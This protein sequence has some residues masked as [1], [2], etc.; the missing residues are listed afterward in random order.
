[1]R[2]D[3]LT[4]TRFVA[5]TSIVVYHFGTDIFPFK[6]ELVSFLFRQSNIGVSYFFTLSGFVMIIAYGGKSIINMVDYYKN[7]I[8]R[9]YPVYLL[10]I[11]ML[12]AYL[13]LFRSAINY[14]GLVLN[15][16]AVQ[17]WI[18]GKA[19]SFNAP[20]WSLSVEFLFYLVFP[21]L[22][23]Y[24]YTKTSLKTIGLFI[25]IFWSIS[26]LLFHLSFKLDLYHP[27][28]S[29]SHDL[30]LYF[31]LFHLNEF[32]IGNL[33]GLIFLDISKKNK[34]NLDWPVLIT[35]FLITLALKYKGWLNINYHNGAL[36]ILFMVFIL[37]LSINNGILTSIASHRF[38]VFLGEISYGI[39]IFQIPV[40]MWM[41]KVLK[42][43]QI[44]NLE[45]KFFISLIILILI[46][47]M[48]YIFIETPLRDK[49]KTLNLRHI[50]VFSRVRN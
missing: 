11:L 32:L 24:L 41:G 34:R 3:Q 36:S 21:F 9:I 44:Y 26:Q 4:F 39:Y 42:H 12:L 13:L 35:L 31:P 10:A 7:R 33:A 1:M 50:R 22:F 48:S 2:I 19:L 20:G 45:L 18:P 23:N 28:P 6:N 46:S 16:F 5:A 49:I 30:I 27:Y 14:S 17:A 43:V 15:L 25:V 40:F 29:K 37:S 38:F 8:A 47:A